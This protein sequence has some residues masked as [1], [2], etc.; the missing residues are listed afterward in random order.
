MSDF[1]TY[2]GT[3]IQVPVGS[4]SYNSPFGVG[5]SN[6]AK[7]TY[8][9]TGKTYLQSQYPSLFS[10][11]GR[12]NAF[13]YT[14]RTHSSI[15]MFT[16]F[17]TGSNF[18]ALGYN[19]QIKSSNGITWTNSTNMLV[20]QISSGTSGNGYVY[21]CSPFV[22][23]NVIA[24]S[25]DEGTTWFPSLICGGVRKIIPFNSKYVFL[26]DSTY[27]YTG[28]G[29]AYA[30]CDNSTGFNG[31]ESGQGHG[32]YEGVV[33]GSQ[34]TI[35][36]TSGKIRTSTNGT[37]W[38]ARTSGTASTIFHL[39]YAN[40][41][42]VYGTS[43]GGIGT[44]TDSITWTARTS[45][46]T[47]NILALTYGNGIYVYGGSGGALSTST[48]AITWTAR[49]SGT[50]SEIR[51]II[52]QGGQFVMSGAGGML[53]TSTDAITW[54]AQTSGTISYINVLTYENGLYL[55]GTQGANGIGTST[56]AITWTARSSG[57][58][59]II[60]SIIWDGTR[61][62]VNGD[63]I[64]TSVDGATWT[65]IYRGPSGT[66]GFED[67]A[68][69]PTLGMVVAI[70]YNGIILT[71]SDNGQNWVRRTNPSSARFDWIQWI[72]EIGMFLG[73][74]NGGVLVTSTDG[75]T[76]TQRT[77]GTAFNIGYG[78]WTGSGVILLTANS[79]SNTVLRSNDG[80]TWTVSTVSTVLTTGAATTLNAVWIVKTPNGFLAAGAGGTYYSSDSINWVQQT[81][82]ST[83]P[84]NTGVV[85]SPSLNRTW[86]FLW[87]GTTYTTDSGGTVLENATYNLNT[88]FVVPK[89]TVGTGSS[90]QKTWIKA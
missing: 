39:I 66:N 12:V 6:N 47:S 30:N 43:A 77:T 5:T 89:Y 37:T 50:T 56:D 11:I 68:Y 44:S 33:V 38:T 20:P 21:L 69:S 67:M 18:I 29:G 58:T 62:V 4:I 84:T 13:A 75:I 27:S 31:V 22:S 24:R 61:Y 83:N 79:N 71:S 73:E 60:Y 54:T 65:N 59:A 63:M 36:G 19:Q 42:Y 64:S 87:S 17:W 49:T 86:V 80:I 88:E 46:T 14:P 9:E 10:V 74:G 90:E 2:I 1:S 41:L 32:Y 34:L 26:I 48:D 16:A 23:G 45:G 52:F 3:Q 72:P 7:G 8:L 25:A 15:S 51:S 70:G 55:Y 40:N 81:V 28:Y 76:W 82:A 57:S 53:R 78:A 35:V 85:Y